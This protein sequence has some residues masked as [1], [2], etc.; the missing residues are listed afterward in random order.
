[1]LFIVNR[2]YSEICIL[3]SASPRP[4][5]FKPERQVRPPKKS[6]KPPKKQPFWETDR[7]SS[8]KG[9]APSRP[10]LEP[11]VGIEKP[12]QK[13]VLAPGSFEKVSEVDIEDTFSYDR[14]ERPEKGQTVDLECH[15]LSSSGKVGLSD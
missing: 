1:M 12:L 14:G 5:K 13:W 15:G 4:D 2:L 11:I 6:G 3:Q 10:P 8:A 7:G 9:R